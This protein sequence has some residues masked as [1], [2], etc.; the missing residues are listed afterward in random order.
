MFY[1]QIV[2]SEGQVMFQKTNISEKQETQFSSCSHGG[3]FLNQIFVYFRSKI[4]NKE[5]AS[6]WEVIGPLEDRQDATPSLFYLFFYSAGRRKHINP[7]FIEVDGETKQLDV[8]GDL[9]VLEVHKPSQQMMDDNRLFD[10]GTCSIQTQQVL[11]FLA[12]IRNVD[13]L[14]KCQGVFTPKTKVKE[15]KS[16]LHSDIVS[17]LWNADYKQ[18]HLRNDMTGSLPVFGN[19]G[20]VTYA[21]FTMNLL[22]G[23]KGNET[24]ALKSERMSK[25]TVSQTQNK[26][27]KEREEKGVVKPRVKVEK[28]TSEC[29]S[30]Q[31]VEK[32]NKH[33]NSK[34]NYVQEMNDLDLEVYTYGVHDA[35]D[36]RSNCCLNSFKL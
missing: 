19:S 3:L 34:N 14:A 1:I 8:S 30:K 28:K 9:I 33:G 15:I 11:T 31:S 10:Q 4:D 22:A 26:P 6:D 27:K 20:G 13:W 16:M 7:L 23:E 18:I 35:M 12:C 21:A 25:K 2:T 36:N 29:K 5:R 24:V 32:K 17:R